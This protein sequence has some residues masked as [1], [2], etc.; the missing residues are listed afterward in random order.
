MRAVVTRVREASVTIDGGC[1]GRIGNG[2][3]VLLGV[4]P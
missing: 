4:G 2:F 1:C 3:L